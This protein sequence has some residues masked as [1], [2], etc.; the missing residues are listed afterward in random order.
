MNPLPERFWA[1]VAVTPSCWLW[2]AYRDPNGYGRVAMGDGPR[3]AHRVAYEA[4]VGAVPDGLDLDHLC[5]VRNCVNPDH[6]EPVSH[7]ENMRRGEF[8]QRDHCAR[9]HEYTPENTKLNDKG[10]RY[11]RTCAYERDARRADDRASRAAEAAPHGTLSG[12]TRWKC[13]CAEC[14]AANTAYMK[15]WRASRV[16]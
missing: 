11:C 16:A 13:R 4:L 7:A 2:V 6:L 8:A 15:E 12:Y 1:K 14:R 9:G 5:R 10:H 3:L